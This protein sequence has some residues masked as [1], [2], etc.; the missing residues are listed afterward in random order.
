M[1]TVP[2][3]HAMLDNPTICVQNV[4]PVAFWQ[5]W[6]IGNCD[7]GATVYA[8][9]ADGQLCLFGHCNINVTVIYKQL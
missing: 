5:L 1:V 3:I 2:V 9:V 4:T 8:T 7:P 6:S